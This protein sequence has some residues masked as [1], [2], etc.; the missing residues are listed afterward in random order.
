MFATVT[1]ICVSVLSVLTT[2]NIVVRCI[3]TCIL[4]LWSRGQKTSVVSLVRLKTTRFTGS[5]N[6]VEALTRPEKYKNTEIYLFVSVIPDS[7]KQQEM[8]KPPPTPER[9]LKEKIV[10]Q[11]NV[12]AHTRFSLLWDGKQLSRNPNTLCCVNCSRKHLT[13]DS[14][15]MSGSRQAQIWGNRALRFLSLHVCFEQSCC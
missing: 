15:L 3:Q 11:P 12:C 1:H 14:C 5:S 7:P 10:S 8:R 9:L 4:N 13:W 6:H 2:N